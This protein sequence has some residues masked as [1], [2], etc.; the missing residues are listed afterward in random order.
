MINRRNFIKKALTALSIP[1]I[2]GTGISVLT[3]FAEPL[4]TG[5][6]GT[7]VFDAPVVYAPYIPVVTTKV[8]RRV[9]GREIEDG[10]KLEYGKPEFQY[11]DSLKE[12]LMKHV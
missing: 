4:T 8:V 10:W 5:Y 3:K 9:E 12:E 2:A 11:S 7:A 6:T 1:L